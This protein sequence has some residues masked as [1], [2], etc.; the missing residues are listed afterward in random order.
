MTTT[1]SYPYYSIVTFGSPSYGDCRSYYR[2]LDA[3]RRDAKTLGGGS[4]TNARIV[5][6]E[7]RAAAIAADI[8]TARNVIEHV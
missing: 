8:S 3:A 7:T 2:S 1:T 4:M 5:G 6:C